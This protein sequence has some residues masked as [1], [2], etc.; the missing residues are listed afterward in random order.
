[1]SKTGTNMETMPS[2]SNLRSILR[3]RSRKRRVT[4]SSELEIRQFEKAV[5]QSS[6]SGKKEKD[7]GGINTV[8]GRVTD[9]PDILSSVIATSISQEETLDHS[10]KTS[11]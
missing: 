6:I 1:M 11:R 4:F 8:S 2:N 3:K 5:E 7:L 10:T 9:P